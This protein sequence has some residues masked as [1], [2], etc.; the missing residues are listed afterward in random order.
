M[1]ALELQ[2]AREAESAGV[3]AQVAEFDAHLQ[4]GGRGGACQGMQRVAECLGVCSG[5]PSALGY[6]AGGRVLCCTAAANK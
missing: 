1:Q 4:Q 5:W 6:A 3:E 2:L